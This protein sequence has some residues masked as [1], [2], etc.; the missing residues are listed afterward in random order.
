M[1]PIQILAAGVAALLLSSCA[2]F[3]SD[4]TAELEASKARAELYDQRGA[5]ADEL[6]RGATGISEEKRAAI[7]AAGARIDEQYQELAS[8]QDLAIEAGGKIT[9]RRIVDLVEQFRRE[10]QK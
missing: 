2:L 1:R 8:E 4:R 5:A 3:T 9:W 6:V 10:R 7:L